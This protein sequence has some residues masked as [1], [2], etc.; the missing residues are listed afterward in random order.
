MD[1]LIPQFNCLYKKTDKLPEKVKIKAEPLLAVSNQPVF[2]EP[3]QPNPY[4]LWP[5]GWI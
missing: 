2:P 3:I 4:F 1:L 5:F